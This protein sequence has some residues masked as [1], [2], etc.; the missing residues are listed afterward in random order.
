MVDFNA[1]ELVRSSLPQADHG[2]HSIN[3]LLS[4]LS[5]RSRSLSVAHCGDCEHHHHKVPSLLDSSGGDLV[6]CAGPGRRTV[7]KVRTVSEWT[8]IVVINCEAE[9]TI[10]RLSLKLGFEALLDRS[11]NNPETTKLVSIQEK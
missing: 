7:G 2:H 3:S 5:K 1:I 8:S 9:K 6:D 10:S 4:T 11:W